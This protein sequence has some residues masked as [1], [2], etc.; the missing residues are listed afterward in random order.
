M[1][2]NKSLEKLILIFELSEKNF[3]SEYGSGKLRLLYWEPS[4]RLRK[5]GSL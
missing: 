2:K 4:D 3:A 1:L 5:G